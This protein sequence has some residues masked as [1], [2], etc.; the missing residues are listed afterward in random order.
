MFPCQALTEWHK[1]TPKPQD[2][3]EK[4]QNAWTDEDLRQNL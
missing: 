4:D 3:L 1:I 2:Q